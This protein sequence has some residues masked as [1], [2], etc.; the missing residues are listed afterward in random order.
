M[1]KCNF[2]FLKKKLD[3]IIKLN[4]KKI[5]ALEALVSSIDNT[6]HTFTITSYNNN[7][8]ELT[9]AQ[10]IECIIKPIDLKTIN[11][12]VGDLVRF[13][14]KL[15]ND[16]ND[17]GKLVI[18]IIYIYKIDQKTIFE[19]NINLYNKIK[20]AL[21]T[22]KYNILM[23]K[24]NKK[25]HPKIVN[26]IGLISFSD[27]AC[28]NFKILFQEK[29]IGKLYVH[30]MNNNNVESMF[31]QVLEYFRK[32]YYIDIICILCHAK[33]LSQ[34]DSLDLSSIRVIKYLIHRKK[35]PYIIFISDITDDTLEPL[36]I[37]FVNRKFSQINDSIDFIRNI[38]MEYKMKLQ[39]S[40]QYSTNIL[41]QLIMTKKEELNDLFNLFE[42]NRLQINNSDMDLLDCKI[43]YLKN[44]LLISLEKE[45][46]MLQNIKTSLF[47]SIINHDKYRRSMTLEKA[48]SEKQDK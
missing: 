20:R 18:N 17:I 6:H 8:Q 1:S 41:R 37:N 46:N 43:K 25:T 3:L 45:R 34:S 11:L 35:F 21:S 2:E 13:S 24:F 26:N 28:M 15:V 30:H 42:K 9:N 38:Q 33:D 7:I 10:Y 5:I 19:A 39:E 48:Y 32:F 29:C 40:I 22:A 36:M 14:G 23:N 44:L 31:I 12:Q 16:N 4:F 27:S 47:E